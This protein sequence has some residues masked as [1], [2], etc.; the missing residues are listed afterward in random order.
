MPYV[1]QPVDKQPAGCHLR[2]TPMAELPPPL[3]LDCNATTP[4]EPAVRDRMFEYFETEYGNA[5]S[6]THAFGARAQ[7]AVEEARERVARVVGA[8]HD[9]VIFTSGATESNNLALLGL[10]KHGVES[11]SRHLITSQIEH[12]AVLEPVAELERRGFEVTRLPPSPAGWV[13]PGTLAA[14]LR[15]DTLL[16]SIMHV[17]NET[18]VEQPIEEYAAALQGHSAFM[19]VDAAQGFGKRLASLQNTRVDLISASAHK[20]YGPKG[21]GALVARR[22]RFRRPPMEPLLHGGGQE[23]GLRAGTLPVPLIV[24]FGE[25]AHLALRD[26]RSREK[27]CREMRDALHSALKGTPVR[28]HGDLSRTL[29]HTLNFGVPGVS[30]EAV[31]V[32]AKR[33]AAFSNG[34]SCTSN[35]RE[36]SHV[37]LAMGLSPEEA[38]QALRLSWCHLTPAPDWGAL[39]QILAS[40]R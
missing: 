36:A 25:A 31:M 18:G 20:L 3:Y 7:R 2:G 15:R 9:E 34:S 33:F 30:A 6:R 12:K 37:L 11:G 27:R 22:R 23:R 29:P 8:E 38:G 17:N 26:H 5:G 14:A 4:L 39:R 28:F 10:G 40:L 32:A 19:H 16:V 35:S 21:V 13:E 1:C 24:G